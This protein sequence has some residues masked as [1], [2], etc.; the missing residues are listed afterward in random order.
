M[1]STTVQIRVNLKVEIPDELKHLLVRQG[2]TPP[3]ETP[4][5]EES[6]ITLSGHR[7]AMEALRLDQH[8]AWERLKAEHQEQMHRLLIESKERQE[9]HAQE[10]REARQATRIAVAEEIARDLEKEMPG[11]LGVTTIT[12]RAA[13]VARDHAKGQPLW[14]WTP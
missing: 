3:G 7:A 14:L 4:P 2:W 5:P 13:K 8:R 11:T 9:R 6:T 10:V 1:A 12:M